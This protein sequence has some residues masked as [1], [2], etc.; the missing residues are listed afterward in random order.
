[1]ERSDSVLTSKE[2]RFLERINVVFMFLSHS[3]L[4]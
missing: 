4:S 1:M 2:I 3:P